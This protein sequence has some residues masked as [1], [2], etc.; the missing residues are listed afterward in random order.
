M[1]VAVKPSVVVSTAPRHQRV[2]LRKE[3]RK[4]IVSLRLL[5]TTASG[6]RLAAQRASGSFVPLFGSET[7]FK[8]QADAISHGERKFG[9]KAS[10][11]VGS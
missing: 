1:A 6:Y 11:V 5:G 7:T 8:K 10:K 4:G 9:V 2:Y 3:I